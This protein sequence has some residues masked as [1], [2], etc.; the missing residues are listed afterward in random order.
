MPTLTPASPDVP[1]TPPRPIMAVVM[2][3]ELATRFPAVA[4]ALSVVASVA[5]ITPLVM[6]DRVPMVTPVTPAAT[7]DEA[8][9]QL[10]S[11]E[12]AEGLAW[13]ALALIRADDPRFGASWQQWIDA[14]TRL[15]A[16]TA[17]LWDTRMDLLLRA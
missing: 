8:E 11:S 7:L 1:S 15:G 2:P 6:A 16:C 17:Q 3:P 4:S 5:S 10:Q 9:R 14:R 12:Q 13:M